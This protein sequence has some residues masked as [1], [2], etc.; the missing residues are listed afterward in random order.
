M[1]RV[2]SKLQ[3]TVPKDIADRYAIRP[4]DSIE[5]TAAA[6]SMRVVKVQT[7]PLADAKGDIALRLRRFDEA[8]QRQA[9]RQR[10]NQPGRPHGPG[11]GWKREDLYDR[12][13]PR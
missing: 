5:W 7:R 8:T 10:K 3:V 12:G 1:G 2:T 4:G 9:Q 13:R 11:R 6:D